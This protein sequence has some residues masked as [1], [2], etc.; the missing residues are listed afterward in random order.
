MDSVLGVVDRDPPSCTPDPRSSDSKWS[1]DG[2][3]RG[4]PGGVDEICGFKILDVQ[5]LPVGGDET[6]LGKE[7]S[8]VVVKLEPEP[9]NGSP[10]QGETGQVEGRCLQDDSLPTSTSIHVKEELNED[11]CNAT[12]RRTAIIRTLSLRKNTVTFPEN[13]SQQHKKSMDDKQKSIHRREQ[14]KILTCEKLCRCTMCNQ[15]FD[16]F[17]TYQARGESA[18]ERRKRFAREQKRRQRARHDQNQVAAR[19]ASQVIYRRE[20]RKN[21]SQEEADRRRRYARQRRAKMVE[22]ETQEE[23]DRRRQLSAEA[24]ARARARARRRSNRR[25]AIS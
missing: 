7:S 9:T 2:G 3:N 1:S 11:S 5:N 12:E 14:M 17:S 25:W 8:I 16:C 4:G 24:M 13:S 6:H 19:R 21:E 23:A 15:S 18:A 22:T 10:S 20:R